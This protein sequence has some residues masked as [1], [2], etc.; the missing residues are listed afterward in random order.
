MKPASSSN[1]PGTAKE[2]LYAAYLL[3]LVLGLRKV[4]SSGLP[5]N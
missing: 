4:K 3:I 2:T 5:G 1:P